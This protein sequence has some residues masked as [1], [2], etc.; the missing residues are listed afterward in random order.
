[1]HDFFSSTPASE[2]T[3]AS[4]LFLSNSSLV[5]RSLS[6]QS[7]QRRAM[8][9]LAGVPF[10]AEPRFFSSPQRA[11][12]LWSP[13]RLSSNE[14]RRRFLWRSSGRGVKLTTHLQLIS[15]SR[16]VELYLHSPIRL[17]GVLLNCLTREIT[18][19]SS[20]IFPFRVTWSSYWE[21]R[22]VTRNFFGTLYT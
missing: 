21:P 8:S 19:T 2:V 12:R 15:K 4:L 10:T 3:A 5:Y 16:M 18:S 22:T 9:W 13:S 7:A 11:D 17:H 20:I 14:H 6:I 1:M